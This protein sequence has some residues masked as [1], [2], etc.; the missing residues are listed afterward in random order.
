MNRFK[1]IVFEELGSFLEIVE[2]RRELHRHPELAFSEHRT[3]EFIAKTLQ[4]NGI[5]FRKVAETGILAEI[6]GEKEDG[7]GGTI[8]LRAD[9]DALP[10]EECNGS[11]FASQT[12]GVMHACGHDMHTAMLLGALK[13]LQNQRNM[14]SGRVLGLFQPAEECNPG[15]AAV[16]LDEGTFDAYNDIKAFIGYHVDPLMPTGKF[17]A[18]AGQYMASSDELRFTIHGIGGHAAMRAYL[19]DPIRAGADVFNMLY[20]LPD[21]RP[22]SETALIAIGRVEA[23]GATNIIPDLF[24]ME[25]TMRT[26]DENCRRFAQQTILKKCAEIEIGQ[27][28]PSIY[29]NVE[30]TQKI[31]AMTIDIFGQDNFIDLDLRMTS[32]DFGHY[33]QHYPSLY[34]RVGVGGQGIFFEQSRAGNVHSPHFNPDEKA[35]SYGTTEL[36]MIVFELMQ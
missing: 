12:L 31:K 17:G 1:K 22:C 18:R 10:L 11:E 13:A 21:N 7:A 34:Y 6:I 9:I 29:N 4:E 36:C 28:Y 16:V 25:G 2:W 30:L 23:L 20:N 35:L 5:S 24:Y 15:G 3:Q 26:F 8:V 27:G 19:K 32:D 33:A 14:F